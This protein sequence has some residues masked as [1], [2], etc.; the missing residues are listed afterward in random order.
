MKIGRND[1]CPC[2][3][4]KKY[5]KC[6]M[7][8]EEISSTNLVT[9]KN[10]RWTHDKVKVLDSSIIIIQM[11]KFGIPLTK[12]EI[13]E[14]ISSVSIA[15]DLRDKWADKYTLDRR[16]PLID[17]TFFAIQELS[18]RF[19]P[20][21]VLLEQIDDMM[22]NGYDAEAVNGEEQAVEIWM[23][24]WRKL[25]TW[26]GDQKVTSIDDLGD[27][28]YRYMSE[29]ISNWVQDLE[30]AL[31]NA[32][33]KDEKYL[34]MNEA[35][36]S[37]FLTRFPD[38]DSLI[39]QNMTLAKGESIFLQGRYTE[40]ENVYQKCAE[41]HPNNAWIYIRWGDLFNPK[42]RSVKPDREKSI[43]L[44]KKAIQKATDEEERLAVEERLSELEG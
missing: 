19:L 35:F 6:C 18:S 41:E 21:H 31:S 23:E 9:I 10:Q 16:D 29:F 34:E 20:E 38:S 37:E 4:G 26:L 40:G 8:K 25:L 2:G 27:A 33:S 43:D 30:L 3:S 22:Q 13:L 17:F 7:D 15:A 5:K 12:E 32:G 14:E 36:T 39:I 24:V 44:Y 42:S 11:V 1:L 28:T